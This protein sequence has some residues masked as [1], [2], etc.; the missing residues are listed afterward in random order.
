MPFPNLEGKHTYEAFFSPRDF[1]DYLKRNG[2]WEDFSLPTGVIF[3]YSPRLLERVLNRE[4]AERHGRFA[5]DFYLIRRH[6]A[7]IGVSGRFGIGP[8][9]VSTI[10]EELIAVGVRN[11]VSIGSAGG[12]QKDLP[13]G[14]IVVCDRAI[15]DEGVSHHYLEPGK[16]AFPSPA[17]TQ[18]LMTALERMGAHFR[19]GATW[20]TDA[21][22][23]ETIEELTQYQSEGVLTVEMEAAALAAVAQYRRAEFATA[24]TISDSLAG[25]VWNPQFHSDETFRGLDLLYE[26]AIATFAERP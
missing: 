12:L 13:I 10:M 20:T 21:P 2:H 25:L 26:A 11:F 23:R 9:G 8:A 18:R 4:P 24:F 15:R 14:D 1:L 22:Y 3:M 16:Y 7:I 6:E 5:G 19:V 17:L